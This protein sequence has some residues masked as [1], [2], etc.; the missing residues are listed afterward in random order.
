MSIIKNKRALADVVA[1]VMIIALSIISISIIFSY[2]KNL[3]ETTTSQLAPTINCIQIQ[4]KL[5]ACSSN[6][7]IMATIIPG[8][9]EDINKLIFVTPT[10]SFGCGS[11][12]DFSCN[13]QC[14]TP[15]IGQSK[16]Y[17]IPSTENN[18]KVIIGQCSNFPLEVN[19]IQ[20]CS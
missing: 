17:F 11:S 14:Q 2:T 15:E 3:T 8:P 19:N 5:S 7:E 16:S 18:L 20:P 4:T 6:N 1:I 9:D 12:N 13:S 10:N